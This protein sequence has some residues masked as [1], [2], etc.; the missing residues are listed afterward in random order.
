MFGG[1]EVGD[2]GVGHEVSVELG[3]VHDGPHRNRADV[4]LC[5]SVLNINL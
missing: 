4:S 2:R 3:G 1:G 5:G